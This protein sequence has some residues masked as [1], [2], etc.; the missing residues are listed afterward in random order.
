[1]EQKETKFVGYTDEQAAAFV[2]T[3]LKELNR[4]DLALPIVHWFRKHQREMTMNDFQKLLKTKR[5]ELNG[6]E[7]KQAV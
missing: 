7:K 5:R 1:M 6:T 3:V 2:Q 4:E